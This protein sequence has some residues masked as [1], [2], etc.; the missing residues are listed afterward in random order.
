M[1][2]VSALQQ[3][4]ESPLFVPCT[5]CTA[6]LL[7]VV[8]LFNSLSKKPKGKKRQQKASEAA[9]GT[10]INTDGLRRSTRCGEGGSEI[11]AIYKCSGWRGT[12]GR[13]ARR[14]R[15]PAAPG[16]LE[17]TAAC[18]PSCCCRAHKTPVHFSE[19]YLVS[20]AAAKTPKA[21]RPTT[22]G[23]TVADRSELPDLSCSLAL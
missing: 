2:D 10:V 16:C 1:V 9:A 14:A 17:R 7:F 3:L 5:V 11:Q 12:G 21:V 13:S 23:V 20:P 6:L 18:A 19:E 22:C 15:R 8:A 4:T